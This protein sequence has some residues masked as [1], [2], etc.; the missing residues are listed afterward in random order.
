[1]GEVDHGVLQE[2]GPS[3]LFFFLS[4]AKRRYQNALWEESKPSEVVWCSDVLL[5]NLAF[6]RTLL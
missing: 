5:G 4:L 3:L 6:T 2:G 1:M